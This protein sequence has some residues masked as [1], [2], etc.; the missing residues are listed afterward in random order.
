MRLKAQ[1]L[2]MRV[3]DALSDAFS[4]EPPPSGERVLWDADVRGLGLRLRMSGG[5]VA[6]YWIYRYRFGGKQRFMSIGEYGQPWTLDTARDEGRRLQNLVAS[7]TNPAD[8]REAARTS[9]TLEQAASQWV[10]DYATHHKAPESVAHDKRLLARLGIAFVDRERNG[11]ALSALAQTRMDL[12]SRNQIAAFHLKLAGTPVQA[13]RC[14]NLLSSIFSW[15]GRTFGDNPCRGVKR[16][17][18]RIVERHLSGDELVRLIQVFQEVRQ[19]ESENPIIV[20]AIILLLLTGARPKELRTARREWLDGEAGTLRIPDPKEKKPKTIMLGPYTL[21][22]IRD[23]PR[24]RGN[25]YL[26][27]G[28]RCGEHVVNMQEVW[29]RIRKRAGLED[30]RLYDLRHTYASI[31]AGDFKES[32]PRIGKL[33]GHSSPLTTAR[34]VHLTENPLRDVVNAVDAKI[35]GLFKKENA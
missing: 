3:I 13:N 6:R 14:L 28:R 21:G 4:A 19:D 29:G 1:H 12:V 15:S 25:P 23:L 5:I 10:R 17:R 2:T 24:Y 26:L 7:K 31:L 9:P 30:V 16:Y 18:E 33:L 22:V 35:A 34:Y 8:L 27:P 32:L 20:G 11:R